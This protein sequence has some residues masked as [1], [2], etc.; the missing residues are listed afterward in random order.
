MT[1]L[2]VDLG[3]MFV[4]H[5][6]LQTFVDASAMA[7]VSKLDGSRNGVQAAN[8]LA[9]AGP[10]GS[11]QPN[12]YNFGTSTITNVTT[13]YASSYGSNY[14]DYST[15]SG[16]AT[17]SYRFVQVTAT[18]NVPLYFLPVIEGIPTG[19]TVT[20]RAVAGQQ[21][22]ETVWNGG[23]MPFLVDGH[24]ATDLQHFGLTPGLQYTLKWGN[25]NVTTCAG[26]AGF[27]PNLAPDA[28]GFVDIGEGNGTSGIRDAIV[29]GG[30][31]NPDSN[32]SSVGAGTVLYQNPGNRGSSIFSALST[33]SDQDTDQVSTT[34]AQYQSAGIGNGQRVVTVPIGDPSTWTGHGSNYNVTV[35]GFGNFLLDPASS[36]SGSSGPICATY[37]GPGNLNGN[38]SGGTNGA[39]VYSVKLYE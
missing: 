23:L 16:S 32:P 20:A 8:E 6:E 35:V 4:V 27:N 1:G 15:A 13:A 31:P 5:N 12:R 34:W 28:H 21:P 18:E 7:A 2:A 19:T 17:N 22:Q 3:K 24:N 38:A 36:I 14:V 39:N 11:A 33:R 25:H 10:L 30:Y 9:T 37:I 29:N 26:D